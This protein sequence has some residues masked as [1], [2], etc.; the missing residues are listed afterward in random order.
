TTLGKEADIEWLQKAGGIVTGVG[1]ITAAVGIA[2]AAGA[3]VAGGG[4]SAASSALSGA[5]GISGPLT[6]VIT[7]TLGSMVTSAVSAVVYSGIYVAGAGFKSIGEA[8]NTEWM[9]T[10][11]NVL[12]AFGAAGLKEILKQGIGPSFK[13]PIP[14]VDIGIGFGLGYDIDG[15]GFVVG[16]SADMRIGKFGVGANCSYNLGTGEKCYGLDAG[17]QFGGT[18]FNGGLGASFSHSSIYGYSVSGRTS[19]GTGMGRGRASA[20]LGVGYSEYAGSFT[21]FDVSYEM[22]ENKSSDTASSENQGYD[23]SKKNFSLTAGV[24][25]SANNG[26][27]ASLGYGRGRPGETGYRS[28]GLTYNFESQ[29]VGLNM[30]YG[31]NEYIQKMSASYSF[32][33]KII[34]FATGFSRKEDWSNRDS[35]SLYDPY[36]RSYLQSSWNTLDLNMSIDLDGMYGYDGKIITFGAGAN[37]FGSNVTYYEN[38]ELVQALKKQAEEKGY[39][40]NDFDANGIRTSAYA[41]R[42][43]IDLSGIRQEIRNNKSHGST[44]DAENYLNYSLNKAMR[45]GETYYQDTNGNEFKFNE[46][47]GEWLVKTVGRNDYIVNPNG[48]IQVGNIENLNSMAASNMASSGFKF[49]NRTSM[50]RLGRQQINDIGFTGIDAKNI[51]EAYKVSG[52]YM[53]VD[54][55]GLTSF[56]TQDP[57]SPAL[58]LSGQM[59]YNADASSY[60]YDYF[61]PDGTLLDAKN[62]KITSEGFDAE[63]KNGGSIT[64]K[65]NTDLNDKQ[66]VSAARMYGLYGEVGLINFATANDFIE[67]NMYGVDGSLTERYVRRDYEGKITNNPNVKESAF[68]IIVEKGQKASKATQE[69]YGF[70]EGSRYVVQLSHGEENSYRIKNALVYE[71]GAKN[72]KTQKHDIGEAV[73]TAALGRRTAAIGSLFTNSG[74]LETYRVDFEIKNGVELPSKITT[75][76]YNVS[77]D[78]ILDKD[79]FIIRDNR[80]AMK[81]SSEVAEPAKKDSPDG[82]PASDKVVA[83]AKDE[84]GPI[85]TVNDDII[86]EKGISKKEGSKKD[87]RRDEIM[88]DFEVVGNSALESAMNVIAGSSALQSNRITYSGDKKVSKEWAITYRQNKNSEGSAVANEAV[89]TTYDKYG[90][91]LT[92]IMSVGA[93]NVDGSSANLVKAALGDGKK[94][95]ISYMTINAINADGKKVQ[96]RIE[97][98]NAEM[99]ADYTLKG[100]SN[101]NIKA[102]LKDRDSKSFE[103]GGFSD[104]TYVNID[105]NVEDK[106]KVDNAQLK[107]NYATS[108]Y[109]KDGKRTR[110][111]YDLIVEGE[112][113]IDGVRYR[114]PAEIEIDG[115]KHQG[116]NRKGSAAIDQDI[117]G[118]D[119]A[120]SLKGL[121]ISTIDPNTGERQYNTCINGSFKP[122]LDANGN[123]ILSYSSDTVVRGIKWDTPQKEQKDKPAAAE[124]GKDGGKSDNAENKGDAKATPDQQQQEQ[125]EAQSRKDEQHAQADCVITQENINGQ[126]YLQAIGDIALSSNG[127]INYLANG[128]VI[129][130]DTIKDPKLMTEFGTGSGIIRIEEDKDGKRN[131]ISVCSDG[132]VNKDGLEVEKFAAGGTARTVMQKD[133]IKT[134]TDYDGKG[135]TDKRIENVKTGSYLDTKRYGVNDKQETTAH[136][137]GGDTS[138]DWAV[139]KSDG[140]GKPDIDSNKF[141]D[142]SLTY[143]EKNNPIVKGINGTT[144]VTFIHSIITNN[145]GKKLFEEYTLDETG[146]LTGGIPLY[147]FDGITK[148]SC[149]ARPG[150]GGNGWFALNGSTGE[151]Y[152]VNYDENN[153]D[154]PL[155][156]SKMGV[157]KKID[158]DD[159]SVEYVLQENLFDINSNAHIKTN[160]TSIT[161]YKGAIVGMVYNTEYQTSDGRWIQAKGYGNAAA[162]QLGSQSANFAAAA[163]GG[164][165]TQGED[166]YWNFVKEGDKFGSFEVTKEGSD[167]Y[168][169][170][171]NSHGAANLP[172]EVAIN[173]N[174]EGKFQL[175]SDE[176]GNFKLKLANDVGITYHNSRTNTTYKEGASIQAGAE[177]LSIGEN[178]DITFGKGKMSL[179]KEVQLYYPLSDSEKTSEETSAENAKKGG[180]DSK[181]DKKS[182]DKSE[183]KT[184]KTV[185]NGSNTSSSHLF[186]KT[187]RDKEGNPIGYEFSDGEIEFSGDTFNPI[188]VG[189]A[190]KTGSE[191][192]GR[193]ITEG[194]L[195]VEGFLSDGSAILVSNGDSAKATIGSLK[196]ANGRITETYDSKGC[197]RK[198]KET[199]VGGTEYYDKES[200]I[201]GVHNKGNMH[202][203]EY[204]IDYVTVNGKSI[205]IPT[206]KV[207]SSYWKGSV[208][209]QIGDGVEYTYTLKSNGKLSNN[210][211]IIIGGNT[212]QIKDGQAYLPTVKELGP[213]LST[214][215]IPYNVTTAEGLKEFKV[216]TE[217]EIKAEKDRQLKKLQEASQEYMASKIAVLEDAFGKGNVAILSSTNDAQKPLMFRD[218]YNES[219]GKYF[220]YYYGENAQLIAPAKYIEVQID[221]R[222]YSYNIYDSHDVEALDR[223]ISVMENRKKAE[224]A[225]AGMVGKNQNQGYYYA[226]GKTYTAVGIID[227]NKIRELK[228]GE[229]GNF[230]SETDGKWYMLKDNI[231]YGPFNY[232][233]GFEVIS[234]GENGKVTVMKGFNNV[235]TGCKLTE[236]YFSPTG[237]VTKLEFVGDGKRDLWWS[238]NTGMVAT[239]TTYSDFNQ[240]IDG[241]GNNTTLTRT[242]EGASFTVYRELANYGLG[243]D[244]HFE[245]K[246]LLI[247]SSKKGSDRYSYITLITDNGKEDKGRKINTVT[248]YQTVTGADG[249]VTETSLVSCKVDERPNNIDF[250]TTH[251][252]MSARETAVINYY[253]KALKEGN[254]EITQYTSVKY[255]N[256]GSV[257]SSF[258]TASGRA[259][260]DRN[261]V[262]QATFGI[263][264]DKGQSIISAMP[265][266]YTSLA[267][268][269]AF[270]VGAESA[271]ILGGLNLDDITFN[272]QAYSLE[273]MIVLKFDSGLLSSYSYRL[274]DLNTKEVF[275]GKKEDKAYY[276]RPSW[277]TASKTMDVLRLEEAGGNDIK[278]SMFSGTKMNSSGS[279]LSN[280]TPTVEISISHSLNGSITAEKMRML[281]PENTVFQLEKSGN[282]VPVTTLALIERTSTTRDILGNKTEQKITANVD[283]WKITDKDTLDLNAIREFTNITGYSASYDSSGRVLDYKEIEAGPLGTSAAMKDV[284]WDEKGRM[285]QYSPENYQETQWKLKEGK[286]AAG[287]PETDPNW[288]KSSATVLDGGTVVNVYSKDDIL[289][290]VGRKYDDLITFKTSKE[291]KKAGWEVESYHIIDGVREMNFTYKY[292]KDGNAEAVQTGDRTIEKVEEVF[293]TRY[294]QDGVKYSSSMGDKLYSSQTRT[295]TLWESS[296]EQEYENGAPTGNKIHYQSAERYSTITTSYYG[297][298]KEAKLLINGSIKG[299]ATVTSE[300]FISGHEQTVIKFD[301]NNNLIQNTLIGIK[302]INTVNYNNGDSRTV[303]RLDYESVFSKNTK[304]KQLNGLNFEGSTTATEYGIEEIIFTDRYGNSTT[305]RTFEKANVKDADGVILQEAENGWT[306]TTVSD[307]GST[308]EVIK[309]IGKTTNYTYNKDRTLVTTTVLKGAYSYDVYHDG[310]HISSQSESDYETIGHGMPI[311]V[312]DP[313]TKQT[314]TIFGDVKIRSG[315]EMSSETFNYV[316][317]EGN[318]KEYAVSSISEKSSYDYIGKTVAHSTE[319]KTYDREESSD[320]T[321]IEK[322]NTTRTETNTY[323]L[324]ADKV[325]EGE[326]LKYEDVYNKEFDIET[327]EDKN[328]NRIR[329]ASS[330]SYAKVVDYEN[331]QFY[332]TTDIGKTTTK[333]TADGKPVLESPVLDKDD[334]QVLDENGKPMFGNTISGTPILDKDGNQVLDKDGKPLFDNSGKKVEGTKKRWDFADANSL[335]KIELDGVINAK[336]YTGT[337]G[338]L[339]DK[340]SYKYTNTNFS[341]DAWGRETGYDFERTYITGEYA[342]KTLT[343]RST[344]QYTQKS[345]FGGEAFT[346]YS[347]VSQG[348]TIGGKTIPDSKDKDGNIIKGVQLDASGGYFANNGIGNNSAYRAMESSNIM[349]IS[350]NN[351]A[352][353]VLGDGTMYKNFARLTTVEASDVRK[354]IIK[355]AVGV[356]VAAV[357]IATTI[358]TCG[359]ASAVWAAAF[360]SIAAFVKISIVL[361]VAA[362]NAYFAFNKVSDAVDHVSDGQWGAFALDLLAIGASFL[363]GG[364]ASG[365]IKIVGGLAKGI[366]SIF[367]KAAWQAGAKAVG[368]QLTKETVKSMAKYAAAG[369]VTGAAYNTAY[370]LAT[371]GWDFGSLNRSNILWSAG[372]GALMGLAMR[373]SVGFGKRGWAKSALGKSNTRSS[374]FIFTA[375]KVLSASMIHRSM[376]E[377]QYAFEDNNYISGAFNLFI[378]LAFSYQSMSSNLKTAS[379][380]SASSNAK[381]RAEA[382]AKAKEAKARGEKFESA[383]QKQT[384][385]VSDKKKQE[386]ATDKEIYSKEYKELTTFRQKFVY[387]AETAAMFGMGAAAMGAMTTISGNL[388]QGINP[389]TGLNFSDLMDIYTVG[390]VL[391]MTGSIF[392]RNTGTFRFWSEKNISGALSSLTSPETMLMSLNSAAHL[393][394]FNAIAMP[395]INIFTAT[396][397]GVW[398]AAWYGEKFTVSDV[399]EIFSNAFEDYRAVFYDSFDDAHTREK[400]AEIVGSGAG[401][402]GV[403]SPLFGAA[404]PAYAF[405]GRIG[406]AFVNVVERGNIFAAVFG[407]PVQRLGAGVNTALTLKQFEYAE[408]I[409]NRVGGLI[410]KGLEKLGMGSKQ[411]QLTNGEMGGLF[412]YAFGTMSMLLVPSAAGRFTAKERSRIADIYMRGEHEYFKN[413]AEFT[414]GMSESGKSFVEHTANEMLVKSESGR[415]LNNMINPSVN[416]IV[417]KDSKGNS[418]VINMADRGSLRESAKTEASDRIAHYKEGGEG[419]RELSLAELSSYAKIGVEVEGV[420]VTNEILFGVLK[421][422]GAEADLNG[423]VEI[424]RQIDELLLPEN[425][426]SNRELDRKTFGIWEKQMQEKET[427]ISERDE[428]LSYRRLENDLSQL[429]EALNNVPKW[430]IQERTNIQKEIDKINEEIGR[431]LDN[432]SIDSA[433]YA[434]FARINE[435]VKASKEILDL[436]KK[437][438]IYDIRNKEDASKLDIVDVRSDFRSLENDLSQLTEALNNVPKWNTQERANIQKEI[439]KVKAE[440][441]TRSG[442]RSLENELSQLTEALNNVPKWNTQERAN[443][444]KEIDKVNEE[445]GQKLDMISIGAVNYAE[446]VKKDA[447]VKAKAILTKALNNVKKA[448][449]KASTIIT[450]ARTLEFMQLTRTGIERELAGNKEFLSLGLEGEKEITSIKSEGKEIEVTQYMRAKAKEIVDNILKSANEKVKNIASDQH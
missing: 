248:Q 108:T 126:Q 447:E 409:G 147:Y 223:Q 111:D 190:F 52:G 65:F 70:S 232:T 448:E 66:I 233:S 50:M 117:T 171:S 347:S 195:K 85:E 16:A 372:E 250:K 363:G 115:V 443:I 143:D 348:Y 234:K 242:L 408:E 166:G 4:I 240:A 96:R 112:I 267:S 164:F 353:G 32:V 284:R 28:Y 445:I 357:V 433:N 320:K 391:G 294:S 88:P 137:R 413:T 329:T 7:T 322:G 395:L 51:S 191:I 358:L 306:Y 402:G 37:G 54:N 102:T 208:S 424:L 158:K 27:G 33:D 3:F 390:A 245:S 279:K 113:E 367:S 281:E 63:G 160:Y 136:I 304:T 432:I 282:F 253:S 34:S 93:V 446:F 231:Q 262:V 148:M 21:T 48:D 246:N 404:L 436:S 219:Q 385:Q 392:T 364:M 180:K 192:F 286:S 118:D 106:Y 1:L 173:G 216:A 333:Y 368:T 422:R 369:A 41:Q 261:G 83:T 212:Y 157:A 389:F 42:I 438:D 260:V 330:E 57:N 227:N 30:A 47:T 201:K 380:K 193:T 20:N 121:Q 289:Y 411:Y 149:A 64:G 103:D 356:V 277:N 141:Y 301:K 297:E 116:V 222:K 55:A 429:T 199:H 154:N 75:L 101:G 81:K 22:N 49:E 393:A 426:T 336:R 71:T 82:A 449:S 323:R 124:S 299:V 440:A 400:W 259:Y 288:I 203:Q 210:G 110:I 86:S 46:E 153:R 163:D 379:G 175:A 144:D 332:I 105:V 13:L 189:A 236:Y 428:F 89:V 241:N 313:E 77:G 183:D 334:R 403:V 401:M 383:S 152:G 397:S 287:T 45:S 40:T 87:N 172:K 68:E 384:K 386:V 290:G 444:Q 431:K 419:G 355:V 315:R 405:G 8:T 107:Q 120:F 31:N 56:Y 425:E 11:G 99:N 19:L 435:E 331:E 159:G 165:L 218:N 59:S 249:A 221:G 150:A 311:E 205:G 206:D 176:Y 268:D 162:V 296:V 321:Y 292:D 14:G 280:I 24:S 60:H 265:S 184:A 188:G 213:G 73:V 325:T 423:K 399:S 430:N 273:N 437:A 123:V 230:Y 266:F 2:V 130:L 146:E 324:G 305:A 412:A 5:L 98:E 69:L 174:I 237:Q 156:E 346:T 109:N 140:E 359:L 263:Q 256:D 95:K 244:A 308:R 319:N 238:N 255:K 264:D 343:G 151:I 276:F 186:A 194:E 434:E 293:T 15:G 381:A 316:D 269:L 78:L 257:A 374:A 310:K 378:A 128:T 361:A 202:F 179:S 209:Y 326:L 283:N 314:T 135:W 254:A 100:D 226:D 317:A 114:N 62:M 371:N 272:G 29:A 366:G 228:Q 354:G 72:A 341:V 302:D 214:V 340:Q 207:K 338:T 61:N 414:K 181:N 349:N 309:E 198:Y 350:L 420:K 406:N 328:G 225:V 53:I 258:D 104:T 442:L 125:Q 38:K 318:E 376:Q 204:E 79:Y 215:L 344:T 10:T 307:G 377:A 375:S 134:I 196:S 133:D 12:K 270:N 220:P 312:F 129:K 450:D 229:T 251:S 410:D 345:A 439:D 285:L 35:E 370:Q 275:Y 335:K 84:K 271:T 352:A 327:S 274:V 415:T 142:F 168:I 132:T 119:S 252:Q 185:V 303:R 36:S 18:K 298:T 416:S 382:K 92:H 211:S 337:A 178:G 235:E 187:L 295:D 394:G 421:V 131:I 80:I 138:L 417:I 43:G 167:W 247:D 224:Q 362:I 97:V 155:S 182:D 342:G 122:D 418:Y 26:F 373:G 67:L 44:L 94:S 177:I 197:I 76:S 91:A 6:G 25:D 74:E 351:I 441:D 39:L 170:D 387:H 58:Y 9:I 396:V 139:R 407:R 300:T 90:N 127:R 239:Q 278:L 217:H 388:S 243:K 398:N 360:T 169:V 17:Y 161:G 23:A 427:M 200:G 339:N 365:A 291:D 145:N